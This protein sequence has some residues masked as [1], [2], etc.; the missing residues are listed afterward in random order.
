[1]LII[2]LPV[3][4]YKLI[5]MQIVLVL[6][7]LLR[8]LILIFGC[9]VLVNSITG[10][11]KKRKYSS[12]DNRSNLF[13]MICFDIQLLAGLVLYFNN[14]WFER[15]KDIG[16][17]M[18]DAHYRFFAVE[19]MLMMLIA[20]VLV[21][22]GRSSVKNAPTDKQKH[23]KMLIY[24]GIALILVLAAIP[25]PFRESIARPLFRIFSS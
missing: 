9:W 17:T 20:W 2:F 1:M 10:L 23:K 8:W 5:Y 4:L 24:F 18:K 13:F 21:H 14:A 19:H 22:I 3:F 11:V 25:W 16:N 12:A 15:L 7:S 6:H